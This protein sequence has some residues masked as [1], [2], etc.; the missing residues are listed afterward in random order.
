MCSALKQL[1]R[2]AAVGISGTL[3]YG[4]V[5]GGLA[6]KLRGSL[7]ASLPPRVRVEISERALGA[8]RKEKLRPG[9]WEVDSC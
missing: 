8:W 5:V 7:A 6:T 3:E 2:L 4:L 9:L 1:P